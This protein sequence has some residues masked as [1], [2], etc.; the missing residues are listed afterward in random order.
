MANPIQKEFQNDLL[1]R[2]YSRRQMLN[3]AALLGSAST[4]GSL[5]SEAAWAADAPMQPPKVRIGTNECWTG[6]M[7]AGLAAL[8]AVGSQCN[9]YNPSGEPAALVR[10][11]AQTEKIP[12]D[13]IS[14]WPGAYS[15]L[16][17]AVIAFCSPTKG[18]VTCDPAYE[19]PGEAAAWLGAPYRAVPLRASDYSHDV[20]AI[21]AANPNAGLYYI[22]NP[23][24]P[25]ATMTSMADIEWLVDNKPA[26]SIVVID[27]AYIHWTRDYPNNTATHLAIANKDVMVFRTFSK[28]FGMAGMRVGYFMAR[29]D[30]IK[31]VSL[32]DKGEPSSQL[33]I[34]SV[35]CATASL[36][37][38]VSIAARRK[39]LM[40]NRAATVELL[41]KR[42]FKV[43]GVS[44]ANFLMVDWKTKTAK[45][46][47][48]AFRAQGVQIAGAR[49]PT[50]PTMSRITI[51]S[52]QDM[53]GFFAALNK[54]AAT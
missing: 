25:T 20:K 13:H 5:N 41:T 22:C 45:D 26:D 16:A 7:P 46:M 48:A 40:E 14:V 18:L 49:W 2:G 4:L 3:A 23:N 19:T 28:I 15:A 50:W 9:R 53:D 8:N 21:L 32:Y 38:H 44:D 39:E 37:D 52:K 43:I 1:S 54:V 31:K 33:P 35:A 30:I 47:Q 6:P 11:I 10:A 51:G 29:P 27:E 17:R 24:N 42:N 12:E 34:P 36:A